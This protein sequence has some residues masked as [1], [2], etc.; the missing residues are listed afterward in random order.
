MYPSYNINVSKDDPAVLLCSYTWQQDAERIGALTSSSADH[1]QQLSDEVA[2]RELV[3]RDLARMHKY[4][5]TTEDELYKL[6]SGLYLDH[7]AHDWTHD[8]NTAGAFAFFRPQQFS[9]L[10]GKMIHPSGNLILIGEACSPHHAWVVGALESAVYGVCL[11][12][13][14]RQDEIPGAAHAIALLEKAEDGNPFVGLPPYMDRTISNFSALNARLDLEDSDARKRAQ[15]QQQ[16][17]NVAL[18]GG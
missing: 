17:Q 12:L 15:R 18:R 10:W 14:M 3:L 8:P 7:Y 5:G 6:I 2:L 1:R 16:Q 13:K 9:C 11:W 4:D